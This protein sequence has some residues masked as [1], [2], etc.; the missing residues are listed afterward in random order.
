M[1]IYVQR[2]CTRMFTETFTHNSKNWKPKYAH[3]QYNEWISTCKLC[4]IHMMKNFNINYN[5]TWMN[6]RD[7]M[8]REWRQTHKKVHTMWFHLYK[9][10]R[11]AKP[12]SGIRSQ[13]NNGYHWWAVVNDWEPGVMVTLGCQN[14]V[15]V[16]LLWHFVTIHWIHTISKCTLYF[17]KKGYIEKKDNSIN[18]VERKELKILR[19]GCGIAPAQNRANV[20]LSFYTV[21]ATTIQL[22][23]LWKSQ[24]EFHSFGLLGGKVKGL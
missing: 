13:N 19:T 10:Q 16:P 12:I 6:L 22:A 23:L 3:S 20:T 8:L 7:I 17:K 18:L 11:Q 14:W 5:Y 1:G 21:R 9:V 2:T 4:Y 15:L 24:R